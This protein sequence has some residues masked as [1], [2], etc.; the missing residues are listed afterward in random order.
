MTLS[1]F[2]ILAGKSDLAFG[3]K[4]SNYLPYFLRDDVLSGDIKVNSEYIDFSEL[5]A[6]AP[7]TNDTS[8]QKQPA[9]SLV[10]KTVKKETAAITIPANYDFKIN[11]TVSKSAYEQLPLSNIRL[12]ASVKDGRISVSDFTAIAGGSDIKMNGYYGKGTAK[13][14]VFGV[15]GT[16]RSFD[17]ATFYNALP[18]LKE[19]IPQAGNA[20][21]KA[22]AQ[23]KAEGEYGAEIKL[24]ALSGSASLSNLK[25]VDPEL[26]QPV[27]IQKG[28][29][30]FNLAEINLSQ[31]MVK[32]GESDMSLTG[33]LSNFLDYYNS[34]GILE[35][36]LQM[37]SGFLNVN[38]LMNLQVAEKK[39]EG[40]TA[41]NTGSELKA[42]TVPADLK[43]N[44]N[45][46]IAKALY[47]KQLS[48]ARQPFP[49][50]N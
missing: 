44:F 35:G 30:D 33:K 28:N 38:E 23:I 10:Q 40:T 47:T 31:L 48:T 15:N 5:M 16:F 43:L 46:S 18:A 34:K 45:T 17:I 6:M 20:T 3:G 41:Q 32:V 1:N 21:G 9:D 36:S 19:G 4:I 50:A 27:Y 8:A 49:M 2:K 14:P 12:A 11:A 39:P 42:F 29:I 25:Y 24:N 7:A 26:T 22:D 13:S 37:K